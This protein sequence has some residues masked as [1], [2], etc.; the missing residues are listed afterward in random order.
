MASRNR[1]RN[2]YREMESIMT[3]VLI[4]DGAAFLLYMFAASRVGGWTV[5]KGIAAFLAIAIS[6]L[7][8]VWLASG[9]SWLAVLVTGTPGLLLYLPVMIGV[10]IL[11]GC[12]TGLCAQFLVNRGKLWKTISE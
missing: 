12:F 5:V 10:S 11:T 3:K 8:L 2:R 4:G 1:S 9:L 6:L 7:G